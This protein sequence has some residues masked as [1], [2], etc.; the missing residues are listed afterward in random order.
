MTVFT[1]GIRKWST[2]LLTGVIAA[3]VVIAFVGHTVAAGPNCDAGKDKKA[4]CSV[5]ACAAFK[6]CASTA[7]VSAPAAQE[8]KTCTKEECIAKCMATGMTKEQAEACWA[9]HGE[10]KPCTREEC[11]AKCMATG[12][13]KEQAEAC[14]AKHGEGKAGPCHADSVM[15]TAAASGCMRNMTQTASTGE[16]K[17]CTKEECVAKLVASGMSKEDAE[18][19]ATACLAEGKCTG[20]PEAG[21][22]CCAAQKSGTMQH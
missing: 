7:Q 6:T 5:T 17:S 12:M 13:T 1:P 2:T 22:G 8:K 11:I 10:G 20:K 14:W 15:Q 16:K 21:K 19:K 4:S 3:F 18:K 9:R